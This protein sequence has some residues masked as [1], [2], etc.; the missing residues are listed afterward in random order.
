MGWSVWTLIDACKVGFP[1]ESMSFTGH[2]ELF[3]C[4]W[5]VAFGVLVS[6]FVILESQLADWRERSLV[7][8]LG[9]YL[10]TAC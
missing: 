5:V 3:P 2:N 7:F 9:W 1:F 10:R 4:S 6:S 8:L